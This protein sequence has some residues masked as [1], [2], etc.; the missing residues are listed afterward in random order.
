MTSSIS[1]KLVTEP[2][3]FRAFKILI[4][5]EYTGTAVEVVDAP[6][7]ATG[8]LPALEVTTPSG[9]VTITESNAIARYIA[10]LRGI[11]FYYS[12]KTLFY[13]FYYYSSRRGS[14]W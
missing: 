12:H 7:D 14:N 2:G 6:S 9:T 3:N 5:A 4:A 10:R 1:Y 13:Y 8:K 11:F